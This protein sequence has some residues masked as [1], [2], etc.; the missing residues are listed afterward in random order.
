M[1]GRREVGLD[2]DHDWIYDIIRYLIKLLII[3]TTSQLKENSGPL[4]NTFDFI[5]LHLPYLPLC[6]THFFVPKWTR[7]IGG[8]YYTRS[9]L[10]SKTKKDL[11]W[12]FGGAYYTWVRIIQGQIR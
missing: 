5:P 1:S 8:A 3:W 11:V 7:K 10:F 12:N 9:P 4:N 6:N 2:A